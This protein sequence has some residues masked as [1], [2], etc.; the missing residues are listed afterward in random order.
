MT[1][2][3]N[4]SILGLV[5]EIRLKVIKMTITFMSPHLKVNRPIRNM[6]VIT[7]DSFRGVVCFYPRI[8]PHLSYRLGLSYLGG[9]MA[10]WCVV[11]SII[12]C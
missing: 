11:T 1:G 9:V 8:L 10:S 4:S 7:D 3:Q 2:A 12:D 5:L 6:T